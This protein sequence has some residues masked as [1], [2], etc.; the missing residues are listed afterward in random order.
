MNT[1]TLYYIVEDDRLS[2]DWPAFETRA[3][4]EA[5]IRLQCASADT[6]DRAALIQSAIEGIVE[7][8]L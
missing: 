3:G 5:W 4:A 6:P 7:K 8:W 2:D 1:K